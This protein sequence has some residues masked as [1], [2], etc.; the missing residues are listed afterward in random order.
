MVLESGKIDQEGV[1]RLR[2]RLGS[3]NRPRQYGVGLF[4]TQASQDAI[5]HFCQGIGD[6][7]PLYW[8]LSHG[9]NS[10]YGKIIAPACFLYSVYW[11]S[12]R[13]GG[14]PGVHGFHAG[15]DWEWYRPIYLDDKI[16]V[17]EQ[18]TDLQ[19]KESEFAGK[20]LIQSSVT[21]YFNQH[22]D[23]IAKTRGWQVRAERDAAKEKQKYSFE[24]YRYSTEEIKA[25]QDAVMN[26]E[27]RGTTPRW[28]EDV[29]VGDDV[30]PCVKGP[31]S[32]GDITAFVAGC[33]GGISHGIQLREMA[34]HPS[35]GFT[36]PTTGAQEAIIRV[37][38]IQEAAESAG[39]P[40]AYDYGCQRCCWMGN[41]LTNWMGDDGF[42][43]K[44]YVELRRFNVVGDTTWCKGKITGKRDE[45]GQKLV[46]MDV[47]GE[48]QRG[49]TSM[50]GTATVRLPSKAPANLP[51]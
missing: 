30:G 50:K 46:D 10:Q 40:G 28:W 36:D 19:E 26:E 51:S 5:R 21:H 33:I 27:V 39:L 43:K 8:D 48:N 15:N 49:E 31:M 47:W 32:H 37:H 22:G 44:M 38:D 42:L 34:R 18:F 14:L 24:P 35:W 6:E 25:I 29:N 4:N 41:L 16:S 3:F 12:G 1:D 7:N 45:D 23:T 13:T 20:I 9:Y 11:C 17:Q 2:S